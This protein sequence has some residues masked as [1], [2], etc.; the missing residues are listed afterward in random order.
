MNGQMMNYDR[1]LE[2]LK[3]TPEVSY[4]NARC[5]ILELIKYAKSKGL[6]P[7]QLSKE[8]QRS[9]VIPCK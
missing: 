1:Y 9:F 7:S 6:K 2:S 3:R 4:P 8:E 5:D